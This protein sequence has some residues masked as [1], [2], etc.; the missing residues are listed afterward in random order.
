[1]FKMKKN[2]FTLIEVLGAI[3]ILT[4]ISL[5]TIP[6]IDNTINK[7]K[8]KLTETQEQQLIKALKDYYTEASHSRELNEGDLD[9]EYCQKIETLKQNGNLPSDVKNPL[10]NKSY[11]PTDMVCVKKICIK[12]S[13]SGTCEEDAYKNNWKYEY[14]AKVNGNVCDYDE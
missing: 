9:A 3:T 1:M 4:I 14:C 13:A 12:V 6:V 10:T 11:E 5:I 7:G 2:G 8:A